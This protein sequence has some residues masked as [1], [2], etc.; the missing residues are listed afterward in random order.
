M[1]YARRDPGGRGAAGVRHISEV[2]QS[3]LESYASCPRRQ[4]DTAMRIE[5]DKDRGVER[6]TDA[7]AWSVCGAWDGP[8]P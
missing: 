6:A 5:G 3:V 7:Q 4:Y 1:L 8:N 2:M